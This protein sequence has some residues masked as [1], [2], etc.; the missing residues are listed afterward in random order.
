MRR[1]DPRIYSSDGNCSTFEVMVQAEQQLQQI[2]LFVLNTGLMIGSFVPGPIDVLSNGLS[3]MLA[4]GNDDEGTAIEMGIGMVARMNPC[5][6]ALLLNSI[7]RAAKFV[8][9][10]INL[11]RAHTAW[12]KGDC[13]TAGTSVL[14]CGQQRRDVPQ[15]LLRRGN[16]AARPTRL[17]AHRGV[18]GWRFVAFA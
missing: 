18:A 17:A 11:K 3:L 9:A 8:D 2:G 6:R 10:G 7:I 4:L 13:L 16:Q 12:G 5:G 1:G 15:G 14:G